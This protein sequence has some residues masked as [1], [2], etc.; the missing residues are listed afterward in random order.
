[1]QAAVNS[2]SKVFVGGFL[3]PYP[4]SGV[5]SGSRRDS[6][7][8]RVEDDLL[9]TP[10]VHI[11]DIQRV[12]GWTCQAVSPTELPHVV[13]RFT[14]HSNDLAVQGELVNAAGFRV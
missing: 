7:F 8:L 11:C 12:L 9:H 14:E 6:R 5:L 13:S 10:V 3:V 2:G 1:M 4:G